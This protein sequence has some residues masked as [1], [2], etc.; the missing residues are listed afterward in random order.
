MFFVCID[1][2]GG[3]GFFRKRWRYN[4][5]IIIMN[6]KDIRALA[7]HTSHASQSIEIFALLFIIVNIRR[8]LILSGPFSFILFLFY[9][10]AFLSKSRPNVLPIGPVSHCQLIGAFFERPQPMSLIV[11]ELPIINVKVRLPLQS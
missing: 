5:N 1:I 4:I 9:S 11:P 10:L 3:Y 2:A 8:S 7:L 6:E